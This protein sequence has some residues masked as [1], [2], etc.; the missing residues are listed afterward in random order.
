[1]DTKAFIK[2]E[3][4]SPEFDLE[5]QYAKY[6]GVLK[7]AEK[8]KVVTRFPPE[9]S[10]YL[11][12]GH[13]KA[14]LLNYHYA[15]IYEGKMILRFDDTN[16]SKEKHEFQE[17]I[18]EDLKTLG[19]THSKLSF[20]SDYFDVI[21][22]HGRDL[23]KRN[24]AYVDNTDVDTMRDQRKKKI[25]SECR[26]FSVDKNL[27]IYEQMIKGEADDYCLRA[28][29]DMQ[30]NNGCMRDPVLARVNRTPHQR[31][32]KKYLLYP[33]Y[34]FACPIVDHIEGVTHAMRTNEYADRIPQYFWVL[35]ALG[36]PKHEIFEYSR[37]N[38]EYT[39][40]SKRKLQWFVDTKRV[41]G[42]DDPR[43][44]TVRGVIRKGIR[45]ETLTEFMLEQ[46]PSKRA[47]LMEWEKLW[48]INKRIIDP[49]C[50]RFSAVKVEKACRL[51]ITNISEDPEAFTVPMSKLNLALGERPLWRSNNVLLDFVDAD[52]LL[53]V[54]EKFTLMNWGNVMVNS[55]EL[56][57]DGSYL[58][59]GEY[60]AEDKDFK[61][62]AKV[63]WL[64]EGIDLLVADLVEYDHLIKTKK[65]EEDVKIEDIVNVNSRFCAPYYVDPFIRTF[66]AGQF[67]Q[68]ER[69]GYYKVDKV[70]K[71]GE[72]LK[73]TIIY[74][75][76]GKQV[77]LNSQGNQTTAQSDIKRETLGEKVENKKNKEKK[78]DKKKKEE[79][80]EKVEAKGEIK[81]EVKE[82]AKEAKEEK[83]E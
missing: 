80:E 4:Y 69:K 68:F 72:D 48:A 57:E 60:L 2:G 17:S 9:P 37:L 83:P 39:C 25:E 27:E 54:G 19:I 12:V 50:P 31:T 65:I 26:A 77:G 55:K 3:I 42:W 51:K 45:V 82:E 10:G 35:D 16:P 22:D 6:Q 81:E 41:E 46:G 36:F 18:M 14:A 74:T 79:V 62:T 66:N 71:E 40:L 78:K 23:I 49:I 73:Y 33:T 13:V 59:T 61:K 34:D 43:F 11:H 64:A 15:K 70:F 44:P 63:T 30:S 24:L 28:K 21:L 1:M 8:G 32:G 53:K 5:K 7:G 20:T 76:D 75:P 47:N 29:I 38:L 52:K 58:L 67:L 56:Q